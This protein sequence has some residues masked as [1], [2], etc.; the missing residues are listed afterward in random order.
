MFFLFDVYN[1]LL[2]FFMTTSSCGMPK[3]P[4]LAS[5]KY[6]NI[7][8]ASLAQAEARSVHGFLF[9]PSFPAGLCIDIYKEGMGVK[10]FCYFFFPGSY[11]KIFCLSMWKFH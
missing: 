10:G 7:A 5:T 6:K 2:M 11:T 9:F 1:E 3:H 4:R 8:I